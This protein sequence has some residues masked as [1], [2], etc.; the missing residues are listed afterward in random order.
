MALYSDPTNDGRVQREAASLAGAGYDVTVY[1]LNVDDAPAG[2][3]S[4]PGV[5][6]IGMRPA[7]SSVLPERRALFIPANRARRRLRPEAVSV[8]LSEY[9]RT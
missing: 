2:R 6:I 4:P 7:A 1:A 9:G 8:G 5:E 3:G